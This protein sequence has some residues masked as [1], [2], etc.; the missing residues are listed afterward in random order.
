M[1]LNG[2]PKDNRATNLRWGSH[3]ENAAMDRGPHHSHRGE[4][5]KNAK[6]TI[7]DIRR[8]RT[9]YDQRSRPHWG[10]SGLAR[11]LRISEQQ[12]YRIATRIY[13]GWL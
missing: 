12:V 11:N 4:H 6:L 1:H 7:A 8:I 2:N 3:A 10:R 9:A 5:N 13:G